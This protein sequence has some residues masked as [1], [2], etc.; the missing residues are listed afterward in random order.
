MFEMEAWEW[1]LFFRFLTVL[2]MFVMLL[3]FSD[4]SDWIDK[5]STRD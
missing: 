1:V 2:T 5:D 4:V 3:C